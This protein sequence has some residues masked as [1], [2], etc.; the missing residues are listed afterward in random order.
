MEAR[1]DQKTGG[2]IWVNLEKEEDDLKRIKERIGSQS[3]S[4][5]P[6]NINP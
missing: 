3:S 5:V 4:L 2:L 1:I 6:V